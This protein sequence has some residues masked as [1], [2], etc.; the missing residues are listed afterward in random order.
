[1]NK[2]SIK[3]GDLHGW[4]FP[5]I[6]IDDVFVCDLLAQASKNDIYK[7]LFCSWA[8]KGFSN[9]EDKYIWE[10]TDNKISSNLPILLCPED[11]DFFCIKV[12]AEVIYTENTVTWNRIGLVNIFDWD[13]EE[14]S[15]SGFKNQELWS[16]EDWENYG[17]TMGALFPSEES[18]WDEYIYNHFRKEEYRR[19][20]WNYFHK[21]FNDEQYIEWSGCPT[22]TFDIK[23]YEEVVSYYRENFRT[24]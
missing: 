4:K 9:G 13:N 15:N 20:N 5:S 17:D 19:R 10:L 7:G 24:F 3:D 18:A 11:Q 6:H 22:F 1:M 2:I 12:V 8:L 16:E 23:E 14:W 21:K